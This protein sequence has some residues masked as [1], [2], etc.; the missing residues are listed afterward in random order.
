MLLPSIR[1]RDCSGPKRI[2][3]KPC[4]VSWGHPKAYNLGKACRR[5][6]LEAWVGVVGILH[7][8]P[9]RL[10]VSSVGCKETVVGFRAKRSCAWRTNLPTG[11]GMGWNRKRLEGMPSIEEG[12]FPEK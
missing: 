1:G 8:L 9:V 11:S 3:G 7:L 10:G 2:G 5:Q 12:P 4:G 6:G